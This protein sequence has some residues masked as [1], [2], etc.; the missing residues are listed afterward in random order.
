MILNLYLEFHNLANRSTSIKGAVCIVNQNR[1]G[2]S[3][4]FNLMLVDETSIDRRPHATAVK[5][6]L[7]GE[8]SSIVK[9]GKGEGYVHLIP[10][11]FP[12]ILLWLSELF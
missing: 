11:N 12:N 6:S 3:L 5:K 9:G 4:G 2:E 7:G 8:S 1:A 10:T